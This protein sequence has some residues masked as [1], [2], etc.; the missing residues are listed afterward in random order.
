MGFSL[1]P[2][3]L[4]AGILLLA[5]SCYVRLSYILNKTGMPT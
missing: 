1:R 2:V 3:I 5:F 4:A